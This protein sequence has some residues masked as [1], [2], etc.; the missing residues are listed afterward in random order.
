MILKKYL[1][2]LLGSVLFSQTLHQGSINFSYNGSE[3]GDFSSSVE[4]TTSFGGALN[5][6]LNDSSSFLMM[7]V[8][9]RDENAFDLFLTVLEDTIFPIQPRTWSWDI[10]ITDIAN[11]IEDPLS[12]STLSVFVPGLDSNFANQWLAFFTDSSNATDSLSLED[13]S[14]F[15]VENL[16]DD[17]YIA[18]QGDVQINEVSTEAIIG[19]FSFTMWKPLFSFTNIN[20]G[21]FNFKPVDLENLSASTIVS[22]FPK[23]FSMQKAYPNPFNPQVKIPFETSVGQTINIS[24]FNI[25]GKLVKNLFKGYFSPGKHSVKFSDGNLTSGIYFL[26]L[27]HKNGYETQKITLIK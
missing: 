20:N 18:T 25:N 14:T 13:L 9:Q 2:F 6:S 21:L 27:H 3:I 19:D 16:L 24:I 5:I 1:I 23:T 7:G 8:T 22:D 11:I 26:T 12:L 15:F 17:A 10:S 4:D